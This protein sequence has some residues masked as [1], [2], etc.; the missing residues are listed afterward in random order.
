MATLAGLLFLASWVTIHHYFFAKHRLAD[1]P[2][3]ERYG[4]RMLHGYVPYRNFSIEYP[5]GAL[6]MFVLPAVGNSQVFNPLVAT[7]HSH[8]VR[9]AY[10]RNFERLMALCGLVSIAL[11]AIALR[12]CRASN[13]K[14]AAALALAALSPLLLGPVILSRFDLWPTMLALAALVAILAEFAWAGFGLLAVATAAKIFPV[15]LLPIACVWVWKRRGKWELAACLAL[16]IALLAACFVPFVIA[17]PHGVADSLARQLRRPLQ[18]ESL[19][20]AILVSLH[21]LFGLHVTMKSGF[22]SQNIAG[23]RAET[24]AA[25]QSALQI[26]V[27]A[28]IWI[29]FTKG[30]ASRERLVRAS[31]AAVVAFVAFGKVLSPQYMIWICPFVLLV[32]GKRGVAASGVLVLSLVLT[33]LWFPYRYFEYSRHF[34]ALPSAFV[35]ARDLALIGLLVTLLAGLRKSA[36]RP[37]GRTI[38]SSANE[39]FSERQLDPL[40]LG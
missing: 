23:R 2:L 13:G 30:A 37:P 7:H 33:Q 36:A 27:L 21:H 3:Y 24:V 11:I 26:A 8:R 31:A 20:A 29:W 38:L 4:D 40:R 1:T 28:A 34:A 18:I 16:F 15:V 10:R 12:V 32:R 25:V 17:A 19:G 5:P 9:N 22:G 14:L 35:L 6:P 39:R